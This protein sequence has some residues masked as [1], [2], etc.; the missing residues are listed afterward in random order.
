[1]PVT[2]AFKWYIV[3]CNS[4]QN[5]FF[6]TLIVLFQNDIKRRVIEDLK[7]I[8]EDL[9]APFDDLL[10]LGQRFMDKFA[11][12]FDITSKFKSAYNKL[13]VG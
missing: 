13:K 6:S 9:T 12:L 10:A 2:F 11:K 1:M 3:T 5:N 8:M 7:A 4:I